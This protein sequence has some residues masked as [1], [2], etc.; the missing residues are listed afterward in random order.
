MPSTLLG[1]ME[2]LVKVFSTHTHTH[3]NSSEMKQRLRLPCD[4]CAYNKPFIRWAYAI[5][6]EKSERDLNALFI[7]LFNG[8]G[9]VLDFN[10]Q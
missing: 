1:R 6:G 2:I 5:Y 9:L 4:M 8:N 10:I 3:K 7:R